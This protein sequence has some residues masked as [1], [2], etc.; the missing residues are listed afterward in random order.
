LAIG[1]RPGKECDA[2]EESDS[3]DS[4]E[5]IA[6]EEAHSG[7]SG[8]CVNKSNQ[9]AQEQ[10]RAVCRCSGEGGDY[11]EYPHCDPVP[12]VHQ[13]GGFE[14]GYDSPWGACSLQRGKDASVAKDS[15]D[16]VEGG[17]HEQEE[18]AESN[19]SPR[20]W[21][22]VLHREGPWAG[23]YSLRPILFRRCQPCSIHAPNLLSMTIAAQKPGRDSAVVD[24]SLA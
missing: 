16:S 9:S 22:A 1:E 6:D 11:C 14:R 24:A 18:A 4:E 5:F 2:G 15:E 20:Y 3:G 7:I 13:P 8:D 17:A 19:E 23:V 12:G 21:F 10:N